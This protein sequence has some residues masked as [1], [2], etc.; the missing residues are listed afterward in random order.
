MATPG[1]LQNIGSYVNGTLTTLIN[2]LH[3][4]SEDI[5]E[6]LGIPASVVFS[7]IAALAAG[8]PYTMSRYGWSS[9]RDQISPYSSMTGVPAVTDDDFSYITSQDLD[10]PGLGV[11]GGRYQTHPRSHSAAPPNPEDDVLIIKNRGVTYPCHFPAYVI[12]DGKLRVRDVRDRVGVMMELSERGT[13][14]IKLLYKGRQLKEPA[15]PVRDYGVKNK[16][17]LMA[18]L[19]EMDDGSSLSEEEMVVVG[20]ETRGSKSK[21][22]KKKSKKKSGRGEVDSASSALDSNSNFDAKS[23]DL[24]A[25]AGGIDGPM[26]K[27]NE[28]EDEFQTK[29]LPM[30]ED[31]FAAPPADPKKRVDDHRKLSESLLQSIILKLDSVETDGIAEVRTRRRELVHQV[32]AV[33]KNLDKAKAGA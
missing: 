10:D 5:S 33:M 3:K 18:V 9:H 32:Q 7:S 19:P 17:E 24:S 21:R 6:T 12:G 16:S 8:V 15:S 28:L 4:S 26:K 30:C 14:R 22:R 31:F 1:A 20:E 13:R 11:T 27:L 29:W 25:T 23:P 2:V